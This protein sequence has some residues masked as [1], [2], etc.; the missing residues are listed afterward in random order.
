MGAI[1]VVGRTLGLEVTVVRT[2]VAEGI[3]PIQRPGRG[4]RCGGGELGRT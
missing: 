2:I 3:N 4:R 1:I